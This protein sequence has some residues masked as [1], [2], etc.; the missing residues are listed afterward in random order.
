MKLKKLMLGLMTIL[1]AICFMTGCT[2]QELEEKT[3]EETKGNCTVT[4]CIKKIEVTNTVEEISAIIGFEPTTSEYSG[5]K[6][7]KLDSKNW[8]TLKYA[9]ESPI[10]QATIDKE[11]IKNENVKLPTQSELK[12]LLNKGMT[13]EDLVET[14]GAEGTLESKTQGSIGYVWADKNG[15]RLGATINNQSK[16]C[17]VASYR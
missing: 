12:E 5:E 10:L 2:E 14:L 8:I 4:E 3:P 9:G 17:T 11:T 15:Q 13:Y 1:C 7:W 16:K 6:T